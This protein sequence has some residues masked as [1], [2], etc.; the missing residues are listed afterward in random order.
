V[1]RSL[2]FSLQVPGGMLRCAKKEV[3]PAGSSTD[4]KQVWLVSDSL[5]LAGDCDETLP[6][7]LHSDEIPSSVGVLLEREESQVKTGGSKDLTP[8]EHE[9][10]GG[11]A[12]PH[13]TYMNSACA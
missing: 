4:K 9:T 7:H 1:P 6:M 8:H 2:T 10:A 13:V 3:V 11:Q 12:G 5:P